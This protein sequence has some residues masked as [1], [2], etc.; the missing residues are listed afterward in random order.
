[1][2]MECFLSA[3]SVMKSLYIVLCTVIEAVS[4]LS[5]SMRCGEQQHIRPK[6]YITK[7]YNKKQH[8]SMPLKED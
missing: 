2:N 5:R 1:M 3:F 8:K 4:T 7:F 6:K